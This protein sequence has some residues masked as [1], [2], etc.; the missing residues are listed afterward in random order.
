MNLKKKLNSAIKAP[1][2]IFQLYDSALTK[3]PLMTRMGTFFVTF[4]IADTLSQYLKHSKNR[5]DYV[6]LQNPFLFLL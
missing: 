1:V 5:F 6:I 3:R 4:S 2:I